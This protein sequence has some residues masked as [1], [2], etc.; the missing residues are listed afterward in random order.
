MEGRVAFADGL[1]RAIGHCAHRQEPLFGEH[2]LDHG[3]A[4]R[5]YADG[6]LM[7]LDFFEQP[8]NLEMIDDFLARILARHPAIRAAVLVD[9]RGAVEDR[10]LLEAVTLAQLEVDRIVRGRDFQRA[11]A[12]FAID[13]GVGDDLY[14]ATYQRQPNRL[15]D[16]RLVALVVG[17]H[18]DRG[19]TEHRLGPRR[20]DRYSAGA[21][22]ER[23]TDVPEAALDVLVI[24]FEIGQRRFASRAP[25]DEPLGAIDELLVVKIDEDLRDRLRQARI[26]REAL[27]APVA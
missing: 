23:V 22:G 17:I 15:A 25:V 24:D 18:G 3:L 1:D 9:V 14:L 27:A 10:N 8:R 7:R 19:V 6:V 5:A 13:R 12:E 16:V 2:R 4:S 26:K 11:G 21:V 20:C